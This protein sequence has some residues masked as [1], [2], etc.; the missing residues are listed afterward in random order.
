MKIQILSQCFIEVTIMAVFPSPIFL[1]ALAAVLS[2]L[3]NLIR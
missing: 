2:L 3:L 1:P